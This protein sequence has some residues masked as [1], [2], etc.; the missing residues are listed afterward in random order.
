MI[1]KYPPLAPLS[2]FV[3]YFWIY[4]DHL[5]AAELRKE[6]A[7]PTGLPALV[8]DLSR[9][10]RCTQVCDRSRPNQCERMPVSAFHGARSEWYLVEPAPVIATVGVQ[11]K[12]GGAAPFLPVPASELH[13]LHIP[14]QDLWGTEALEL[15]ERLLDTPR[16]E[17]RVRLLAEALLA[18]A[19]CPF[20][21]HPAVAFALRAFL[22]TPP[23]PRVAQVAD[24]IG[25]SQRHFRAVFR[26]EV[27]LTPK[28]YCRV[29]RF[30]EVL[31]R[32]P[33]GA[34]PD[35]AALAVT[36]GYYDQAHLINEFRA[37]A[38]LCPTA[39]ARDRHPF[40]PIYVPLP[41]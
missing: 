33:K 19:T 40:I 7:L 26:A 24:Q 5:P 2:R 14:L 25:L 30:I 38:G 6:H 1:Q 12:P 9:D 22:Q 39:Y 11:F 16:P 21:R 37:L 3:D 18:R 13:N 29:R 23:M 10:E 17:A 35:W 4:E 27:G 8:I 31:Q 20:V 32:T 28:Q 41:M 34:K 36:C 15:R